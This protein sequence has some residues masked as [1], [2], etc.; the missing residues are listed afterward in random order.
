MICPSLLCALALSQSGTPPI[1]LRGE[2]ILFQ[3]DSITDGNRGRSEDPNHILGHGYV[4]SIAAKYGEHFPGLGLKFV[5]RGISGNTV[6]DLT[7]RWDA[8]AMAVKPDVL[9]VLIGIND[10][11]Q[12][13][14]KTLDIQKIERRYDELLARSRA[15]NPK[16]KLILG[17]PFVLKVGMVAKDA[18]WWTA[19]VAQVGSVVDRLASKY[20]A[21][22]VRFQEAFSKA[23][24]R[25]AAEH[26]I[27]DGIHPTTSGHQLMADAWIQAYND[28]YISPLEDPARNSAIDPVVNF[29]RD[30]YNWLHRHA[31][32]LD[33]QKK[34]NPDVALIG[35]SI[36]HFWGGEPKSSQ[37]NGPTSWKATFQGVKALNLGYGWDRTQNVL[38]RLQHG[39]FQGL[40]P[41][42]VVLNIGTNNLV[43]D[44]TA[45]T[46]TPEEVAAGIRAIVRVLKERSPESKIFVMA[47]FPRG[48]DK[49]NE[50][51][52]RI[53]Q[54]N[55]ILAKTLEGVTFLDIGPKLRRPDG[56]ISSEILSDGTHPTD[57][58]YAIWG[59]ALREVGVVPR[60]SLP[61]T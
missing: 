24:E 52:L 7:G 59:E 51:D 38:W 55:E 23:L 32:V 5:N 54:L 25:A 45:R 48:F 37:S 19:A 22:V 18:A 14:G 42:S 31:D 2:T 40:K 9:S 28:F 17:Q 33:A 30:S 16:L 44:E 39:E 60:T 49:G 29:E 21:P 43:G 56:S 57:K 6:A 34:G 12:A 26:W 41:K 36:T 47:V 20:N 10:L 50:L 15:A 1:F 61:R 27:W 3:G 11:H 53:T 8:D 35:D 13:Q 4:F 58:G 46:N